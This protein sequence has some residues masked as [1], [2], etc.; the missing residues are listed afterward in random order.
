M[1]FDEEYTVRKIMDSKN[2]VILDAYMKANS[3]LSEH[4]NVGVSVSGGADSDVMLDL[5][6]RARME[7]GVHCDVTY[8]WFD[9][10]LEYEATKRHIRYLEERYETDIVRRKAKKPIPSCVREYGQPFLSKYV[11]HQI[12]SLQRVEFAWEDEPIDILLDRYSNCKSALRWWCNDYSGGTST[13]DIGNN[14][15]LREFMLENPPT[16]R[17]SDKC[18]DYAKKDVANEFAAERNLDLVC[19]G[20]RKSEGGIRSKRHGTTCYTER[21]GSKHD[22]YRPLFWFDK[23]DCQQ[24]RD[25]F[26]IR[27]SDCYEVWGMSRTGCAGCPFNR[28][29]NKE[30]GVIRTYEP[31]IYKAVGSVFR[32][33]YEYTA[34]Y[35]QYC[36]ERRF[37]RKADW[38]RDWNRL[39]A[40]LD[41]SPDWRG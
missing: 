33:A 38:G 39:F 13:F 9:T 29:V 35:R 6:E 10:G 37:A 23:A 8:V 27:R 41:S 34:M 31:K 2:A 12:E 36:R 16:F 22:T 28:N 18:C 5:I 3:V 26:S 7:N 40:N 30:L 19:I 25:I 14:R 17:I 21:S 20:V 4:G 24:Y 11:S 1:R 32:D 15:F